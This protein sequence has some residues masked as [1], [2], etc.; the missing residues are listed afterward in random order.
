MINS[1]RR[2]RQGA[3]PYALGDGRATRTPARASGRELTVALLEQQPCAYNG[4][5]LI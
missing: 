4:L 1:G 5:I 2:L 3:V